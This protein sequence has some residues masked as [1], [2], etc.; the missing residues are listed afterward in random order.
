VA[1]YVPKFEWTDDAIALRAHIFD[2]WAATGRAP[3]LRQM[4]EATGLER[5]A[6]VQAL[7]LLQTGIVV[8]VDQD[9]PNCDILK[10]PPYSAFPSQVEMYVDDTFHS[11]IGCA[12]EA[13]A[14]SNMPAHFGKDVRLESYCAC[15]LAPITL[16]ANSFTVQRTE[17]AD[18]LVHIA[19]PPWDWVHDDM[20]YMCDSTNLVVDADHAER[21]ERQIGRRGVLMTLAQ[22]R[23]YVEPAVGIR[24]WDYHWPPQSMDPVAV[25]GRIKDL[26][27]D[28]S[29]WDL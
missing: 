19:V 25:I 21:Y 5:R 3:N 9:S 13:V 10:A 28:L 11:F 26:G 24:G 12:H 27:V 23:D 1:Q 22:V 7:K 15:C 6:I 29:A 14:V 20:K 8:V 16:W 17:P 18:P 4:H 2:F